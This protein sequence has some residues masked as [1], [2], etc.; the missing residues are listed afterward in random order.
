MGALVAGVAFLLIES[1][2]GSKA[3][4]LGIGGHRAES[5]RQTYVRTETFPNPFS[6]TRILV[7]N[8]LNLID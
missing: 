1:K 5:R 7:K 2:V 6:I 4:R 8:G 3:L